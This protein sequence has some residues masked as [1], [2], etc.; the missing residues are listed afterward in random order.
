MNRPLLLS[1]AVTAGLLAAGAAYGQYLPSEPAPSTGGKEAPTP[2]PLI[3]KGDQT[4]KPGS[5]QSPECAWTGQR[6]VSVLLHDDVL[7]ANGFLG[8]YR[9]FRC[10]RQHLGLAF[11]CAVPAAGAAAAELQRR[12]EACWID[13]EHP[14]TVAAPP[15]PPTQD[16][17]TGK[18]GKSEKAGSGKSGK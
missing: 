17:S 1:T 11:G 5:A 13:P 7:A 2:P 18:K 10:P 16:E 14:E 12:V 3:R 8:F 4:P 6:L 9:T 15:P